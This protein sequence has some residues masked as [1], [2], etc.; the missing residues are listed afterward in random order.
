MKRYAPEALGINV[1]KTT[2]DAGMPIRFP[3]QENPERIAVLLID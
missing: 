1:A 2:A 3:A